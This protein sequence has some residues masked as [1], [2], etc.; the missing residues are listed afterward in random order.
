MKT[1]GLLVVGA[2]VLGAAAHLVGEAAGAART[3]ASG[4]DELLYLPEGRILRMAALGHRSFLADLVWLAAIQYYGEQRLNAQTYE[5]A[6][7]LFHAIYDLDPHFK[8]ATRFGALVLAQDAANPD[9][10][11]ALL[12]RAVRDNPDAW[13]YPFDS[14]FIYH[15]V[16]RDYRAAGES[17]RAASELPG[18]PSITARL[19]GISFAR[20][21]DRA[22]AR[23]VWMEIL[24]GADNDLMRQVAERNLANLDM[25]DA[26]DLLEEAVRRFRAERG[27]DPGS[28]GELVA[29]GYLREIPA[30]PFGGVYFLDGATGEVFSTTYVDRRMAQERDIFAGFMRQLREADGIW[31]DALEAAAERGLCRSGPWE[32]FGLRL[33]YD[34]ATGTVSWNPPWPQTE[35]GRHGRGNA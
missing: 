12:G 24:T 10:A 18:A 8:G 27:R 14:G 5:Q 2:L 34:P 33:D 20:L 6:E 3:R 1:G 25:E 15:T 16:V 32:P 35:P 23:D 22:S 29:A 19:A 28:W 21:G 4:A 7:R 11:L 31:P 9:G 13:E 30:E 17:Y 26:Q